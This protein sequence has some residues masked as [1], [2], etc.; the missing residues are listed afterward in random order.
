MATTR[1]TDQLLLE[2]LVKHGVAS[3]EELGHMLDQQRKAFLQ[4]QLSLAG[5][6]LLVDL[7]RRELVVMDYPG[8]QESKRIPLHPAS[9]PQGFNPND[10]QRWGSHLL[11]ASAEEGTRLAEFEWQTGALYGLV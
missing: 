5:T 10:W 1:I 4:H 6:A 11:L 2:A 8:T 9:G 7:T 3:S